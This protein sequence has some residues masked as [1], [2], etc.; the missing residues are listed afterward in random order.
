VAKRYTQE[1]REAIIA[2]YE[3]CGASSVCKKFQIAK[4]TLYWIV[5][6]DEKLKRPVG[7]QYSAKDIYKMERL[8][9]QLKTENEILLASGLLNDLS[10]KEKI[11]V[12]ERMKDN[13]SVHILCQTLRLA[14]GT[15]YN[16]IFRSPEKT[17]FQQAD[18]ELRPLIKLHFEA[19]N[20][21]FGSPKIRLML[22]R[23]GRQVSE[24]HISRL[25]KEM[26]LICKQARLRCFNSTHRKYRFRINRVLKNF[27]PEHPNKVWVSDVSYIRVN[28][29]FYAICVVIDL[30]SR[31]VLAK[32]ISPNND[33]A[34]VLKTMKDAFI[35]REEPTGLTFH[36]DQGI[37]YTAFEFRRYLFERNI[38]QSFSNPGSPLDNAVAESFFSIMK[39]EELSHNYYHSEEELQKTVDDYVGFFNEMRPH[40]TLG[41][42]SPDKYEV[43]YHVQIKSQNIAVND[44]R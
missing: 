35:N 13:Y 10:A 44:D 6:Q 1:E 43:Q 39:R 14:K 27:K 11:A 37:Q 9:R 5:N 24:R 8:I 17:V 22:L 40:R 26:G 42:L 16:A 12:V 21:R 20:E 3:K 30:F 4:S 25:M 2:E 41:D 34:L 32:R 28:Q 19:S 31:K 18:E 7:K 29:D 33:L 38:Q 36:S 23:E 15:Y